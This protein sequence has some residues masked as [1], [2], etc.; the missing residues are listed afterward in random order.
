V[1]DGHFNPIS[2]HFLSRKEEGKPTEI[3][4]DKE[5]LCSELQTEAMR[6]IINSR[7]QNEHSSV[8]HLVRDS[9]KFT[10]SDA[11]DHLHLTYETSTPEEKAKIDNDFKV[12]KNLDKETWDVYRKIMGTQFKKTG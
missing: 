12:I 5:K 10:E 4:L 9:G 1:S 2:D 6:D 8:R 3:K 11:F 7:W